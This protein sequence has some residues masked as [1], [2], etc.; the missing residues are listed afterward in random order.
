MST[1]LSTLYAG[2]LHCFNATFTNELP[3][4]SFTNCS[5]A[6]ML[7]VCDTIDNGISPK[8]WTA[9]DCDYKFDQG[10]FVTPL[11]VSSATGLGIK[12]WAVLGML[13]VAGLV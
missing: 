5:L 10:V 6:G 12:G 13:L 4:L 9:F 2:P 1:Q 3:P 7:V 11:L 8:R